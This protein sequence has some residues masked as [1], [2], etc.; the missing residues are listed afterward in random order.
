MKTSTAPMKFC[1]SCGKVL[2]AFS[3]FP[4]ELRRTLRWFLSNSANVA[5]RKDSH[6]RYDNHSGLWANSRNNKSHFF[7]LPNGLLRK[8]FL[9]EGKFCREVK[10]GVSQTKVPY[11]PQ[12]VPGDVLLV[13][14]YSTLAAEP[15]YSR[16]V[17]WLEKCLAH[18]I[19]ENSLRVALV[20]HKGI[21]KG[22]CPPHGI[23]KTHKGCYVRTA[24][25][26]IDKMVA[27]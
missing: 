27:D 5:R 3:A 24:G 18:L 19:S 2:M 10:I 13:R 15:Q 25:T 22:V 12:P 6:N 16:R 8:G 9:R 7:A 14:F 20:E 23:S 21:W 1:G 17:T 26:V 11:D 4:E